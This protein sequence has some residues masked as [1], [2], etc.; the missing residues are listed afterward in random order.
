MKQND[1]NALDTKGYILYNLGKDEKNKDMLDQALNIF[2]RAEKIAKQNKQ[3][4]FLVI[5]WVWFICKLMII[6][7]LTGS[8]D[9]TLKLNPR[10]AEAKNGKAVAISHAGN[11]KEEAIELTKKGY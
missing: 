1:S 2:E 6:D 4:Y 8:F 11:N 5:I 10:F 9:D 3:S 7:L